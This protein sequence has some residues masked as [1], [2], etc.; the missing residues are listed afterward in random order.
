MKETDTISD[1]DINYITSMRIT[2]ESYL[3]QKKVAIEITTLGAS[4][5]HRPRDKHV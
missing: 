3:T 4:V 2:H 1:I 5:R